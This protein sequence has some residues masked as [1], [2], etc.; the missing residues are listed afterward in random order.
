MMPI[1]CPISSQA[2]NPLPF[3]PISPSAA[4]SYPRDNSFLQRKDNISIT[5]LIFSLEQPEYESRRVRLSGVNEMAGLDS[6]VSTKPKSGTQRC[7]KTTESE[8]ALSVKAQKPTE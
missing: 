3:F 1:N 4:L 7:Q 6:A 2:T 5:E 8:L